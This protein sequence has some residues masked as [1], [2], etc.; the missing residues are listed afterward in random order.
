[1]EFFSEILYF[2]SGACCGA[3]GGSLITIRVQKK[4]KTR[5][6]KKV[7]AHDG[8]SA[9]NQSHINAGGDVVAGNK[10]TDS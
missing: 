10:T 8:S 4:T 6:Q 1:M 3:L 9:V 7:K 2:I 5:V